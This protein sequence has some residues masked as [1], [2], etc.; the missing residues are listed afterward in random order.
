MIDSATGKIIFDDG[1]IVDPQITR[2]AFLAS[3]LS[4]NSEASDAPAPPWS[5]FKL[6]PRAMD[7]LVFLFGAELYFKGE[8][9]AHVDLWQIDWTV[10]PSNDHARDSSGWDDWTMEGEIDRQ[11]RNEA[12]LASFLGPPHECTPNRYDPAEALNDKIYRF[13][14]GTIES[15]FDAKTGGTAL[16]VTYDSAKTEVAAP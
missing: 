9:L 3:S 11:K 8:V 7:G 5:S 16:V 1:A 6:A 10:T 2:T 12:W 14:W 15:C 4:L 13:A